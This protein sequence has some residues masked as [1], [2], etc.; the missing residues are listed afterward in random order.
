VNIAPFY[1]RKNDV[2]P[3]TVSERDAPFYARKAGRFNASE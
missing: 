2:A 1:V 3:E